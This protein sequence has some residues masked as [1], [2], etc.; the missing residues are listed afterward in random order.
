[1]GID[2]SRRILSHL[3]THHIFVKKESVSVSGYIYH[4]LFRIFLQKK[5]VAISPAE[6]IVGLHRNAAILYEGLDDFEK[7]LTHFLVAAEFKDVVRL[8]NTAGMRLFREG[9]YDILKTCLDK[10]P[11][12]YIDNFPWVL[13][14]YGKLHGVYGN[15]SAA[16]QSYGCALENFERQGEAK[17]IN[18]CNSSNDYI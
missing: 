7:A 9:K 5:L 17:G 8:L 16:T 6:A 14:L 2:A 12:K 13:C 10:T 4:N 11:L 3:A 1:M 15:H 18:L